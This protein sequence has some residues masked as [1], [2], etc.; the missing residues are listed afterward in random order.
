MSNSILDNSRAYISHRAAL[1][2]QP[3]RLQ[4]DRRRRQEHHCHTDRLAPFDRLLG[5]AKAFA[6]T[7]F[8]SDLLDRSNFLAEASSRMAAALSCAWHSSFVRL[9]LACSFA[10]RSR[11]NSGDI[12]QGRQF[13]NCFRTGI[14]RIPN[15]FFRSAVCASSFNSACAS[16]PL[17][18]MLVR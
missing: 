16:L 4:A 18:T 13:G 8:S 15:L 7:T 2:W 5:H 9:Q 6:R 11:N 14:Y 3:G 12:V 1:T 10:A 17:V